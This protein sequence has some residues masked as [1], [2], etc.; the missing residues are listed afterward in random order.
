MTQTSSSRRIRFIA[1]CSSMLLLALALS[2]VE[3][4]I[5]IATLIPLP[6]FKPGFANI[7][8]VI[9]FFRLSPYAAAL[10]SVVRVVIS[11]LLFSG[12]TTLMFSLSGAVLSFAVLAIFAKLLEGKIGFI[13]LSVLMATFH[14]IG[15]L[16]CAVAVMGNSSL[17]YYFPA[18]G[19]AALVCGCITGVVLT[20]IPNKVYSGKVL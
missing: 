20:V 14:N 7:V 12:I 10:I 8:I 13:G 19:L 4:L 3:T 5:P 16:L 6:G 18:L 11:S 9:A 2:Y 1:E 15:Q 17:L